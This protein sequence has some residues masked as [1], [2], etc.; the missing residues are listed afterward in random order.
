M[1]T[2]VMASVLLLV[3][4]LLSGCSGLAQ[5]KAPG[6]GNPPV[7][8]ASFAA[9]KGM[10]GDIIKVYLAAEDPHGEMDRIAVQVSQVGYGVYPTSWTVVKP[11]YAKR[12]VGYIQWDTYSE[13]T[14]KMPEWTQIS[15]N[16]TVIDKGGFQSVPVVL[17]Y[18]FVTGA[19]PSP[20]LPAP[21]SQ[22]RVIPRIGY[23]DVDLINPQAPMGPVD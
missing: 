16:I 23:I 7:I 18:Q 2:K 19:F 11:K 20:P 22:R 13:D 8:T 10:Y 17:P 21:F 12:F 4:L 3:G 15:M 14:P 5:P 9:D 6:A 1:N